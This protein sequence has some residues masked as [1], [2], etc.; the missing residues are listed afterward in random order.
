M[1]IKFGDF[2]PPIELRIIRSMLGGIEKTLLKQRNS[3]Q[4][5]I[6]ETSRKTFDHSI[7]ILKEWRIE[8]NSK[9]RY[10]FDQCLNDTLAPISRLQY[11]NFRDILICDILLTNSQPP[12]VIIGMIL[13]EVDAAKVDIIKG[14]HRPIVSKHKTGYLQSAILCIYLEIYRALHFFAHDII[15][16]L[17]S[18]PVTSSPYKSSKEES[19]FLAY[20]GQ[21]LKSSQIT[22]IVIRSLESTGIHFNGTDADLRKAAATLTAD[23]NPEMQ[24]VVSDFLCHSRSVHDKF[25]RVQHG[26]RGLVRAFET[27]QSLQS[28]PH[29]IIESAQTSSKSS[30]SS[31]VELLDN[32]PLK[33]FSNSSE[34]IQL[35]YNSNCSS[36]VNQLD[37]K[38]NSSSEL[39]QLDNLS[40]SS[41]HILL[42]TR[43][44]FLNQTYLV[45]LND[46]GGNSHTLNSNLSQ[47]MKLKECSIN[48]VRETLPPN[49]NKTFSH[50]NSNLME[51][52]LFVAH[53]K[54]IFD[55]MSDTELFDNIFHKYISRVKLR[56]PISKQK[57]THFAFRQTILEPLISR[58][59]IKFPS[60]DIEQTI[61]TRL[62]L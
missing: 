9:T 16:K 56:K 48:L 23:L 19:I 11:D 45:D 24:D 49:T 13:S 25:Y 32:S 3:R 35:N 8:R 6:M 21:P 47:T 55:L 53:H 36:Q 34:F 1:E 62:G 22:P 52:T 10:A 42:N 50:D 15:S 12:G 57:V 40:N 39:L 20:N 46:G 51:K 26:Q 31:S 58:L 14:Y 59:R 4:R 7:Y 18:A 61:Y 17:P 5:L 43:S 27:I 41:S 37:N 54:S 44:E 2:L 29:K 38:Y 60:R 28:N 33:S 30:A